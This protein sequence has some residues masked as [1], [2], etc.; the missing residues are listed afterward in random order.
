MELK[1][2]ENSYSKTLYM[3]N[4]GSYGI[5]YLEI[6]VL[7]V[8]PKSSYQVH[9]TDGF[10]IQKVKY[11]KTKREVIDLLRKFRATVKNKEISGT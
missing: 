4:G 1:K 5:D 2:F 11:P 10:K 9:L 3:D 8:S 7:K 6:Q